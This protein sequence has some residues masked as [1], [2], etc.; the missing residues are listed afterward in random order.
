MDQDLLVESELLR[1]EVRVQVTDLGAAELCCIGLAMLRNR[2]RTR[3]SSNMYG[4]TGESF[5]PL[6]KRRIV[7]LPFVHPF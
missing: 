6:S 7:S 2:K 4:S 5:G 1:R 3:N